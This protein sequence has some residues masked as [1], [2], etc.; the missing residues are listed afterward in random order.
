MSTLFIHATEAVDW[1]TMLPADH[2]VA[3][4]LRDKIKAAL[5]R[6]TVQVS[7][8]SRERDLDVVAPI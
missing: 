4:A 7:G 1:I 3:L 2:P 8:L 6:D 5:R